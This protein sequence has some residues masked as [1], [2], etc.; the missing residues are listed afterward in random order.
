MRLDHPPDDRQPEARA[1]G[2]AAVAAP[3]A[4][5][6]QL[7]LGRGDARPPVHHPRHA[8]RLDLDLDRG[9]LRRMGEGVL[10]QIAD[11]LEQHLRLAAHP[12]RTGRAGQ[13][14]MPAPGQGQGRHIF[15][16]PAAQV[17]EIDPMRRVEHEGLQLRHAQQLAD[18]AAHDVDVGLDL[19]SGRAVGQGAHPHAQD[20]QR[21]AQLVRRVGGE[22]PLDAEALLEPVERLVHR[23]GQGRDLIG[24]AIGGQTQRQA[25]GPDVLG[26]LRRLHHRREGPPHDDV[27]GRHQ[28]QQQG[29]DQPGDPRQEGRDDVVDDHVGVLQVLRHLDPD[30]LPQPPFGK[31]AAIIDRRAVRSLEEGRAG[32]R[33]A[34]RQQGRAVGQGREQH[35]APVVDD[36]EG[37]AGIGVLIEGAQ[38]GRQIQPPAGAG[39]AQRAHD[40]RLVPA[41]GLVLEGQGRGIEQQPHRHRQGDADRGDG[42]HVQP[43]DP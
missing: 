18:D 41:H 11:R 39:Q 23:L 28:Q 33:P 32:A 34:R 13:G 42:D 43:D 15:H 9:A 31:G 37:E 20:R 1:A 17:L 16:H 19:V 22:L 10:H 24:Q 30:L 12:D 40:L 3:E 6:H 7:A 2:L 27:V 5:E 36:G 29:C 25:G 35:P 38:V 14:Q 8:L 26:H 21:R 4:L